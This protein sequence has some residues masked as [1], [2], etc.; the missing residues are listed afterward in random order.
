MSENSIIACICKDYTIELDGGKK[1]KIRGERLVGMFGK[2]IEAMGDDD[3]EYFKAACFTQTKNGYAMGGEVRLTKKEFNQ[4]VK[5]FH[6][7]F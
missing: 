5:I 4:R 6:E 1:A 3:P 7:V 2:G